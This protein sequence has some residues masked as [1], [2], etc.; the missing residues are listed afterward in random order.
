M[1]AG[2]RRSNSSKA[3][4]IVPSPTSIASEDQTSLTSPRDREHVLKSLE[5]IIY[6]ILTLPL[7]ITA[8]IFLHCIRDRRRPSRLGGVD[9]YT[10]LLYLRSLKF[11]SSLHLRLLDYLILPALELLEM[12]Q[13][14]AQPTPSRDL[15]SNLASLTEFTITSSLCLWN[16]SPR[17]ETSYPPS[18]R[19]ISMHVCAPAA[20]LSVRQAAVEEALK[21]R[22]FRVS[23]SPG[24]G[25]RVDQAL[26]TLRSLRDDGLGMDITWPPRWATECI[27]AQMVK[28]L[29][30]DRALNPGLAS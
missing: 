30:T 24:R 27:D 1:S 14:Y 25:G 13:T 29:G 12:S 8:E 4:A 22:S 16:G 18:K 5:S 2:G 11:S 7:E 21:L 26:K 10:V 20:M 3:L 17:A 15:L 28:A 9:R 19:S 6:P 23:F